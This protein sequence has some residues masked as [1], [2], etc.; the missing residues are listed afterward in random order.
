M[1]ANENR[2]NSDFT[3]E[4]IKILGSERVDN[5]NRIDLRVAK[6]KR[7]NQP[8]LEKRRVWEC[9]GGDR[10]TKQ[11]GMNIDDLKYIYANYT[12]ILNLM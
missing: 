9:K 4:V 3:C 12:D 1:S 11:V 2:K 6:W 10:P 5:Q 8:V 7:A